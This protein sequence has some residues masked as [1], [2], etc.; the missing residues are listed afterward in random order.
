MKQVYFSIL[1][2][3]FSFPFLS[4]GFQVNFQGQKQQGMGCSGTALFQDG[5][6]LFF[7]PGSTAFAKET[8]I[9]LAITPI[10]ANVLYV[11]SA[12]GQGYRT[13]NPVGTPF[14]VYGLFNLKK[15]PSLK[16]GLAAY[17]PF[18]STVQWGGNW[19]GRFA[20]TRLE[21][22]AIFIQPTISYRINDK[23]GIGAGFVLSTGNVNLQK[24]IPVQDSLGNYGHAELA[25]KALGFGYNIGV[26]YDVSDKFSIGI[27]YRSKVQM[28]LSNG[29]ATFTVPASLDSNFPD[30]KFTGGLP[31]PQVTTIGFAYKPSEKLTLVLDVNHVGWKAYDTLAFD[32]EKNTTSLLDTKSARNYKNI[33]AFR[34]GASYKILKNMDVRAGGGFGF[35]PVQNGY[36]TPETPDANRAYGTFGVSYQFGT[37]FSMDGSLYYTHVKRTDKNLETNLNGTFTT[38]AIAPGI[39]FVYTF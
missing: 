36:V 1:F 5:A 13:E 27:T 23:I 10:F 37:H 6:S 30:G 17:T 28:N 33:F 19:I 35:T 12:T 26:H 32:Y 20:L 14:S 4:Q 2:L 9:N 18:G 39:A 7:N 25:G 29:Q 15:V 31:L 24:D 22:K 11:D 38:N 34:G 3:V 16:L 8:S 21:L